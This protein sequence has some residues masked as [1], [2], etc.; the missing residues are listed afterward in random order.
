MCLHSLHVIASKWKAFQ[1]KLLISGIW[2]PKSGSASKAPSPSRTYF[3]PSSSEGLP[4]ALLE[5]KL[6]AGENSRFFL[7]ELPLGTSWTRPRTPLASPATL[8]TGDPAVSCLLLISKER[9]CRA[10][11]PHWGQCPLPGRAGLPQ[12]TGGGAR[13]PRG[14]RIHPPPPDTA[15]RHHLS[16]G[17]PGL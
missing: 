9:P 4:R 11:A 1:K 3:A 8:P 10:S 16:P 12:D 5:S 14:P 13:G 2:S 6:R 17:R 7:G 15:V